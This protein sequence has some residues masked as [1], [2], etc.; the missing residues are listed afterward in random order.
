MWR[1]RGDLNPR[2]PASQASVPIQTS[3]SEARIPPSD[4]VTRL[5]AHTQGIKHEDSIIN[6]LL[7][8]K[9]AGLSENTL[10]TTSQKLNQLGRNTDLMNPKEVLA[11]IANH[12]VANSTKT[13]LLDCY[14]NFCKTNNLTFKK[15]KYRYERKIPLIPTT[16]NI[17]KIISVSSRK[18][19][20]LF[21]ILEQTGIATQEL[22]TTK[23]TDIDAEQGIINVQGCKGHNSRSLK[24]KPQ[25]A[26]L[27]RAYLHKYTGDNPF[28]KSKRIGEM[29]RRTRNRLA[30]KLNS[31]QLRLIP[32]RNLRH[33]YATKTYDR[34][35]DILL[36]M[37]RLGHKKIETT[38]LY[39]QLVTFNEEEEYTCK[40]ATNV[41]EAT[42]LIEN[43][44][45]Y[46][47]EMDGFKLFRKRK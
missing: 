46:I 2:S 25:T 8:M 34:T 10:H 26:D 15:P 11:F 45:Q 16:E 20:T 1:A 18:Y 6:T 42:D 27:L 30:T 28:P 43:G 36:V 44:F 33:H 4:M 23:R 35:K 31:P 9:S 39:T 32:L 24:L 38:M 29:W 47:T 17:Y 37:Q 14:Q 22:A 5:R 19:A 21:T 41:K 12:K 40:T 7:A 3:H 13:K